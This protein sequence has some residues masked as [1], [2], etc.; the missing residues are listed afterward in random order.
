[1]KKILLRI[2]QLLVLVQA[3]AVALIALLIG[4]RRLFIH[5]KRRVIFGGCG[6]V[7]LAYWSEALRLNGLH[8]KSIVWRT[9]SIYSSDTFDFDLYK[10]WGNFGY[11]M[12]PFDLFLE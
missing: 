12:A 7:N 9:P 10:R 5:Q 3:P 2:A 8:S 1:V 6:I 11:V 4:L